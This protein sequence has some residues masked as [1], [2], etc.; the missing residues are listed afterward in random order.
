MA[1][2]EEVI[3]KSTEYFNGDVLAA[4]V[5]A[6]KYSLRDIND[7]YLELT[8]DDMHR[9]LAKEFARIESKYPNPLTE[10]EIFN[11]IKGFQHIVPQGSPMAGVGNDV[12]IMSVSNCFVIGSPEDSYGGI[13]KADEEIAQL[14]K[15]R[16]GIGLDISNIRPK[17]M[18]TKNAANTTDGISVFMDRFSNTCREVAQAGRRGAELQSISVHHPEIETFI[19]IKKDKT[20][21]TGA[22]ISVK[23]S[24]EFMLAVKNNEQYEQRWPVDSKTPTISN[25][26][27]AKKI[28]DMIIESAWESAEPGVLFWD[29]VK[30]NTPSESYKDCEAVSTNPCFSIDQRVLT[31]DGYIKFSDLLNE[32]SKEIIVDN[33]IVFN[34][35]SEKESWYID[36]SN[37]GIRLVNGYNFRMTSPNEKLYKLTFKNGQELKVTADHHIATVDGMVMAKDLTQDDKILVSNCENNVSIENCLPETVDEICSF[38]M[39]LIAGDGTFSVINSNQTVC[40]DIWGDDRFRLS[41]II[42]SYIDK[43][44]DIEYSSI[45]HLLT[46]GWK[47]RTLTKF[48]VLDIP[49]ENKLR[50][51]SRFLALLLNHRYG[52]TKETKILVPEFII[53]NSRKKEALFYCA[54]LFYADASIQGSDKSGYTVRLH[55]SNDQLLRDVQ[56][57]LHSNGI[58]SSIYKRRDGHKKEIKGKIYNIKPQYELIT[59]NCGYKQFKKIGFFNHPEKTNR[60][61]SIIDLVRNSKVNNYTK[62]VSIEY[63]GEEPVYCLSEDVSRSC[64]VNTISTRRCGEIV[65]PKYD[66]CR[67]ISTN[68]LSFVDEPY[69]INAKFNFVKF[70]KFVKIAQKLMDDLVDIELEQI[71]KILNKIASDPEPD[72]VKFT[73]LNLWKKIKQT[74]ANGRRTGLGITALGD[75][76]AALNIQYGSPE[77]IKMVEEIYK[78]LSIGAYESSVDMAMDRGSFL[79]FNLDTEFDNVFIQRVYNEFSESYQ[80]KYRKYGRRNIALTTTPPAGSISLLT[81]TSS[82]IEPVFKISYVRRKKIV[83]NS[84][85]ADFVDSLGDRWEEFKVYHHQFNIW[86]KITGKTLEEESPWYKATSEDVDWEASVDLQAA[87]Q[88]WVCHSISKTCNLPNSATKELVAN[89]YMKAWESGC[90]GF[91]VYRDGCRDGVLVSETTKKKSSDVFLEHHSPKR[92][93]TLPCDIHNVK[94]KGEQWTIMVGLLEGKPFEIFGGKSKFVSIPKKIKSGYLKKNPKKNGHDKSIYDLVFGE[95]EDPTIIK[96]IAQVFENPNEGE[97]TR[98]ISL[99]LRHGAPVVYVVEQM[100]KEEK[101]DMYS[102]SKVIGRVLKMYIK[103][104]TTSTQKCPSC[105]AKIIF[106][107]GCK[108]C[109]ENCGYSACS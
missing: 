67:L 8:P 99:S 38:L 55:Q 51:N 65:L 72:D 2:R 19:K 12:Q 107:E 79:I 9:R 95:V 101:S 14:A 4:T 42:K 39:G 20:R 105:G 5:F 48:N 68:T 98:I 75:T 61:N 73:E 93:E 100:Q 27:D 54:G 63:V 17:G 1:T 46:N 90:K 70:K 88:K 64:I 40:I 106:T 15:R 37:D 102:F 24:E 47:T 45:E 16:A 58:S 71:D 6:D 87:A 66:S 41:E 49:N 7:S 96:D 89:V 50:I 97:F 22:N 26:V 76:I 33:R 62:M 34:G 82:G 74:C 84:K 10:E 43:L 109:S 11:S 28:W 23:L 81:Q 86:S 83:N 80:E 108:K 103:E 30:K 57:I 25:M 32:P 69:T 29:N 91:T 53:N 78:T 3:E 44:Y 92:P 31:K 13:M 85:D 35:T 104:G 77:S 36:N 60:L 18:K 94:I 59:T 21:V 56:L 52:F